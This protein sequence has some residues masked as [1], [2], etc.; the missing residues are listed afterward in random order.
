MAEAVKTIAS[1][2]QPG[3][4]SEF[5]RGK[6]EPSLLFLLAV[7]QLANLPM[8][9]LVDDEVDLPE[10]LPARS[11]IVTIKTEPPSHT[12]SKKSAPRSARTPVRRKGK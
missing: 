4:I 11:R 12:G 9:L 3:H 2:P 10:K 1:P 6:R 5:E 8:E 7:T